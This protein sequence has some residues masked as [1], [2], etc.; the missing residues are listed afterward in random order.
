[1]P[2]QGASPETGDK[3]SIALIAKDIEYIKTDVKDIKDKLESH[4]VTNEEFDPI[5]K[6]V[7]GIVALVLTGVVGAL[8]ALVIRK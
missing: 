2:K 8:L 3:T 1:M 5:K 7:Y 4:Y 6:I